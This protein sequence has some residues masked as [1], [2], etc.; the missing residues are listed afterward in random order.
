[1]AEDLLR[2]YRPVGPRPGLRA[3]ILAPERRAW[4]WAAAAAALVALTIA[5]QSATRSTAVDVIDVPMEPFEFDARV[6]YLTQIMGGGEDARR[7]AM[8]TVTDEEIRMRL[9]P[10]GGAVPPE[11]PR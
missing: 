1:M 10:I 7:V 11:P 6:A 3:R 4:P 5:L 8:L 9:A 2:K